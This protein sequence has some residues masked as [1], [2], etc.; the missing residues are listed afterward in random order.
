[1]RQMLDVLCRTDRVDYRFVRS[2][3]L[4][5]LNPDT[6]PARTNDDARILADR[7]LAC[8]RDRAGADRRPPNGCRRSRTRDVRRCNAGGGA[9]VWP[10]V[11]GF[12]SGLSFGLRNSSRLRRRYALFGVRFL[13]FFSLVVYGWI[14]H[15]VGWSKM[16]RTNW[17]LGGLVLVDDFVVNFTA[18]SRD[19]AF[20]LVGAVFRRTGIAADPPG[21]EFH[22]GRLGHGY[23]ALQGA[24]QSLGLIMPVILLYVIRRDVLARFFPG[25]DQNALAEPLEIAL[26][27][28]LVL[29]VSPLFIRLAWPTR[30]LPPGPLRRRLERIATRVDFPFTDVLIWDTGQHDGEERMRHRNLA[31]V[32]LMS[33]LTDALIESLSPL[34]IAAVFGHEIGHI[35]HRHLL[36]FAFFFMG[37]LGVLT[38]FAEIVSMGGPWVEQMAQLTPWTPAIVSEVVQAAGSFWA[39]WGC[40]SGSSS[41]SFRGDSEGAARPTYSAAR[42][43][44][45]IWR[46]APRTRISTTATC[47]RGPF[48]GSRTRVCASGRNPDLR[49][50]RPRQRRADQRP[51]PERSIVAAAPEALR[52]GSLFWRDSNGNP[53][54]RAV[55]NVAIAGC[56][57][58][59]ASSWS[60]RSC[61]R[62]W[63]NSANS[64]RLVAS[65]V[66]TRR[67]GDRPQARATDRG[68]P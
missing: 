9:C 59:L 14:I 47:H 21:V 49:R 2:P 8:F 51:R 3:D 32:S 25:W 63:R 35:A 67:A 26:L 1:M 40:I 55:S 30:S 44:L 6:L 23:M 19:P 56:G 39:S 41:A 15:Y 62:S 12:V 57:S 45:V 34:E 50:Q 29:A 65:L 16:V 33:W 60:W 17:G 28:T 5:L 20:G 66:V 13:T 11:L 46:I 42:L 68:L 58:A 7:A 53:M 18:L 43:F 36:Y 27:G 38:V 54:V 22:G 24:E 48:D 31:R 4:C 10:R 52:N 61:S 37:S 64:R